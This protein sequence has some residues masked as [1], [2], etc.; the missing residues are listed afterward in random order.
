MGTRDNQYNHI[1][2]KL[3]TV[4]TYVFPCA[5][6]LDRLFWGFD[7]RIVDTLH[8]SNFPTPATPKTWKPNGRLL[9]S[10]LGGSRQTP[11]FLSYQAWL[12]ETILVP[13]AKHCRIFLKLFD[14]A[15]AGWLA[16]VYHS[17]RNHS[18]CW[19]WEG[20]FVMTLLSSW[21]TQM[22][23]SLRLSLSLSVS[24]SQSLFSLSSSFRFLSVMA[25]FFGCTVCVCITSLCVA[26]FWCHNY[27]PTWRHRTEHLCCKR[28]HKLRSKQRAWRHCRVLQR[29]QR[30]R[31]TSATRESWLPDG[32]Q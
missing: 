2:R 24:Q 7:R 13:K 23:L 18:S 14:L 30:K 29:G 11:L 3:K 6:G 27:R 32:Q 25:H 8:T 20:D 28:A 17:L 19:S 16:W 22:P 5:K 21:K 10:W 1:W 4:V 26:N 31:R 9:T 12:Q 15:L